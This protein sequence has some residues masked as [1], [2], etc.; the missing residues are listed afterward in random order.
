MVRKLIVLTNSAEKTWRDCARLYF[1]SYEECVKPVE[2]AEALAFGDRTHKALEAWW[3]A[4]KA[5][6]APTCMECGVSGRTEPR[7]EAAAEPCSTCDGR[8]IDRS[9][10]LHAALAALESE[11]DPFRRATLEALMLG[12]HERWS[13]MRW[14]GPPYDQAP[15]E[16]LGVEVQFEGPLVNP[17]TG[18]A[19]KTFLNGGKIDALVRVRVD[20][21]NGVDDVK[22][23]PVYVVEH[24]T[25]SEDFSAGSPYRRRLRLD[26][27][28]SRYH[29]GARLL[30]YQDVAGVLYDV[31]GKP[32]LK[33]LKATPPELRKYTKPTAKDPVPRLYAN[34]R[35]N[36]ETPDEYQDRVLASIADGS[37]FA[38]FEV[39][40]LE[41]EEHAAAVDTWQHA[42]AIRDARAR[43]R[44]PRNTSS[45]TKYGRP[46][47]Y[48]PVCEG[49]S[50]LDN[51]MRYRRA[52]TPHEELNEPQKEA[53]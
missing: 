34:Q 3:K 45:C 52:E 18:G 11:P 26:T 14:E 8:G 12:Y 48:M 13:A 15:L 16:V 49:T 31:I 19:S 30:G 36:D 42:E 25:T 20:R 43:N 40:R 17:T 22:V 41:H 7:P 9:Q 37:S 4:A 44:W 53:A 27:Q 10:W 2:S 35:E 5:H 28:V 38:R 1:F 21:L 6:P 32:G 51:P 29:G 47:P 46:C 24:K 50:T 33:P 23:C 39:V